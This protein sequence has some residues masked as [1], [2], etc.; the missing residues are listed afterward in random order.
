[1]LN[2]ILSISFIVIGFFV[3]L[4]CNWK[5]VDSKLN[6]SKNYTVNTNYY[7]KLEVAQQVQNSIDIMEPADYV[8][9]SGLH[10]NFGQEYISEDVFNLAGSN[11]GM[12]FIS[13]GEFEAE[14]KDT[15]AFCFRTSKSNGVHEEF[16]IYINQGSDYYNNIGDELNAAWVLN[17]ELGHAAG[18]D[19]YA[20]PLMQQLTTLNFEN[21]DLPSSSDAYYNVCDK[22]ALQELYKESSSGGGG[23]SISF[24]LLAEKLDEE[25]LCLQWMSEQDRVK[26]FNVYKKVKGKYISQNQ[27]S[28]F[29]NPGA[30]NELHITLEPD[31][32]LKKRKYFLEIEY[33]NGARELKR[34]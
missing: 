14:D 22:I 18:L 19:H 30:Y 2:K 13:N 24:D 6:K 17:H 4:S 20:S 5:A 26:S 10:Y 28:I 1:M 33:F 23:A 9:S 3:L 8:N 16:D 32:K 27:E 34:F 15:P 12:C 11:D 7:L 29:N 21:N 25:T 31:T